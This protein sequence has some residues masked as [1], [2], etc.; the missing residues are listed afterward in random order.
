MNKFLKIA[1]ILFLVIILLLSIPVALYLFVLPNV[2]S[3][4]KFLDYVKETLK[5]VVGAQLII[6]KP[7]LKT[8]LNPNIEFKADEIRLI[9][10]N[11]TLLSIK[12][13]A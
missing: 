6:E 4:S 5:N 8:A 3:N 13:S 9:K 11:E 7:I 2:V 12:K 10:N 1:G